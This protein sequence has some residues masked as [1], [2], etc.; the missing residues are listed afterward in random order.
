MW[1]SQDTDGVDCNE[2][3]KNI[4]VINILSRRIR[5]FVLPCNK[6]RLNG[7]HN[8]HPNRGL[9]PKIFY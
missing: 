9:S 6:S 7:I 4:D 5:P 1:H 2:Y 3:T 8:E